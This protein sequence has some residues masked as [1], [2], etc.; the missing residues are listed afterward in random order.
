MCCVCVRLLYGNNSLW[1]VW[2]SI[3]PA[4]C[5]H[6]YYLLPVRWR[7]R[8][9]NINTRAASAEWV[10]CAILK[11]C[12]YNVNPS[13]N[14]SF[15]RYNVACGYIYIFV[16]SM[17]QQRVLCALM[18]RSSSTQCTIMRAQW[19]ANARLW[20]QKRFRF[21][22]ITTRKYPIRWMQMAFRLA[23][24]DRKCWINRKQT[25]DLRSVCNVCVCGIVSL[26]LVTEPNHFSAS[27][28]IR[29]HSHNKWLC[30]CEP[31][32]RISKHTNGRRTTKT[33]N[34]WKFLTN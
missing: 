13:I 1:V 7:K 27:A 18:M 17:I 20:C 9:H 16:A 25:E 5:G 23:F 29:M 11:R 3:V 22:W 19:V 32:P 8:L 4:V 34:N 26:T 2:C 6:R 14:A 12:D 28:C 15:V 10:A 30:V 21:A 33:T 24:G 31:G